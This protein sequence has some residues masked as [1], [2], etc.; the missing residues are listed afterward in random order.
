MTETQPVWNTIAET[1]TAAAPA[2]S[3]DIGMCLLSWTKIPVEGYGFN[4]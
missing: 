4:R 2:P 3:Y 1:V